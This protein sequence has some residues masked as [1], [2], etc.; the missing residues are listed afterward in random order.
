[1]RH[2]GVSIVVSKKKQPERRPSRMLNGLNVAHRNLRY[3][4]IGRKNASGTN[5][6]NIAEKWEWHSGGK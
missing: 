4:A 5:V 6:D 3:V 2:I 1:M